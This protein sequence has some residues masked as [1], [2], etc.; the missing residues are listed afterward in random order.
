LVIRKHQVLETLQQQS[1]IVEKQQQDSHWDLNFDWSTSNTNNDDLTND[2]DTNTWGTTDL[3]NDTN[4]N[5]SSDSID[6]TTNLF[7]LLSLRD[8]NL[9]KTSSQPTSSSSKQSTLPTFQPNF[10]QLKPYLIVWETFDSQSD[11]FSSSNDI[12]VDQSRTQQLLSN[13]C[14]E[15]KIASIDEIVESTSNAKWKG[16]KYEDVIVGAICEKKK[17]AQ[18]QQQEVRTFHKFQ[19]FLNANHHAYAQQICRYARGEKPIWY[20]S[21]GA[22]KLDKVPHCEQCGAPRVFEMQLMPHLISFC[23]TSKTHKPL[24]DFGTVVIFSCSKSCQSPSKECQEFVVWQ[25]GI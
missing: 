1:T 4:N 8:Q 14:K 19:K 20:S 16:E 6:A 2:N 12:V 9:D 22:I 7:Q 18:I 10:N 21:L 25:K 15:E 23:H 13:Y 24:I 3:T 5:T 17:A 11:Y